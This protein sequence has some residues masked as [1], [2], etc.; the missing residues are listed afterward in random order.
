MLWKVD[1]SSHRCK[2]SLKFQVQRSL[3]AF[4]YFILNDNQFEL[5]ALYLRLGYSVRFFTQPV[6]NFL[7][8]LHRTLT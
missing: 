8:N 7:N 5:K 4:K 3:N 6:R 2:D 1:N